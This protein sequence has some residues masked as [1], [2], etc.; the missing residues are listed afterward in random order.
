MDA[1]KDAT[2]NQNDEE[3]GAI[4]VE[5]TNLRVMW[6]AAEYLQSNGKL[7]IARRGSVFAA[8]LRHDSTENNIR[9]PP[10]ML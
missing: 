9:K 3:I 5:G 6:I 7:G 8:R 2:E 10:E 4:R 1:Q